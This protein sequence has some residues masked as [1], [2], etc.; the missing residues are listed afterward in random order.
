MTRILKQMYQAFLTAQQRRV[1]AHVLEL[2][3]EHTLRD[4]GLHAEVNALRERIRRSQALLGN[5]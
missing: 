1:N 5:Y 2:L 4:I 3:D